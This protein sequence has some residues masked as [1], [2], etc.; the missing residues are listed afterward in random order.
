MSKKPQRIIQSSDEYYTHRTATRISCETP[1]ENNPYIAK[2]VSYYGYDL[3]ELLQKRSYV[4]VLF[5]LFLG[6]LPSPPQA[7]LLESLLIALINPGPRHPATRAAM[8]AGVGKTRP[9]HILPI[10]MSVA[11]GDWLGGNEVSESMLWLKNNQKEDAIT[12]AKRLLTDM[13]SEREGDWH[14]APGFGTRFGT[15]DIIPQE[16]LRL[17]AEQPGSGQNLQ[18]TREFSQ[19]LNH[20]SLG[21]LMTGVAAATLLDLGFHPRAGAG[22]FQLM[23][24]PGL[25]AHGL[26]LSNKPRTAMP[27]LSDDNYIIDNEE[28]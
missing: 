9:A 16:L 18:W 10:A 24:A 21:C 7:K 1:S 6:E 4:D 2:Q 3:L 17:L 19:S 25:L 23:S 11:G 27:F 13:P 14:I 15:I 28:G 20:Q 26:E 12:F 22:L 8:N 5:L